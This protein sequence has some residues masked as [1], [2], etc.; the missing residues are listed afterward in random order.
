M[1]TQLQNERKRGR[2]FLK[3]VRGQAA[4][5]V[6]LVVPLLV[7]FMMIVGEFLR[8]YYTTI[9]LNNAA[10]AGVQY[11]LHSPANAANLQGMQQAALT[12]GSDISGM[13]AVATEQCTC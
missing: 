3:L 13:A 9:E 11:G 6:A 8:V 2:C 1:E 12:D 10:R 5:E 7:V 4:V